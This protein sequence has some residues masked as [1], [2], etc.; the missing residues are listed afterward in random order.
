MANSTGNDR[1][2][3]NFTE[4]SFILRVLSWAVLFGLVL[5]LTIAIGQRSSSMASVGF[6]CSLAA[7]LSGGLT[8][9]L[10]GIPTTKESSAE[11]DRIQHSLSNSLEQVS[12]WLTKIILGVTL[13]QLTKIPESIESIGLFVELRLGVPSTAPVIVGF[14]VYFAI[15]G[16]LIAYIYTRIG[17]TRLLISSDLST[18]ELRNDF[19]KKKE[20]IEARLVSMQIDQEQVKSLALGALK[21]SS[22]RGEENRHEIDP[23]LEKL[24]DDYLAINIEDDKQ[25]VLAEDQSAR[26]MADFVITK[27]VSRDLLASSHHEGLVLALAATVHVLPEHE[28][29]TRLLRV[30]DEVSRQHVK[31]RLLLAFSRLIEHGMVSK[32]DVPKL[33]NLFKSYRHKADGPL[34]KRL[35]HTEELLNE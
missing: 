24:A 7:L 21:V 26:E 22:D 32:E 20:E 25:R 11:G 35:T 15:L 18:D 1:Q 16:F 13:T 12:D 33:K 30:A 23:E 27:G 28:D 3:K 17:Y 10:F 14:L 9:F 2:E 29:V 8:G 34:L 5:I 31:Y 4:L 6:S 19:R